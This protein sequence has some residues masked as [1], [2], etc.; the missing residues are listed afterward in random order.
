MSEYSAVP[1][2]NMEDDTDFY[3]TL[4]GNSQ[5]F[6]NKDSGD[7]GFWS[8]AGDVLG[9][10]AFKNVSGLTIGGLGLWNQYNA[11]KD[12]QK[13]AEEDMQMKR[14]AFQANKER[15]ERRRNIRFA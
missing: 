5:M 6:G 9:S 11:Q 2:L 15:A 7:S 14:E 12:A 10:N 13:I 1:K 4:Y 8:G 3:K